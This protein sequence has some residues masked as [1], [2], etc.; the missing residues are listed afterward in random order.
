M[1]RDTTNAMTNRKNNTFAMPAAPEAMPP[2]PKTAAMIATMKKPIAQLSMVDS[3]VDVMPQPVQTVCPCCAANRPRIG[4]VES[5]RYGLPLSTASGEAAKA[6]REGIDLHLS[7][8]PGAEQRLLQAL[9]ADEGF[10]LAHAALARHRQLYGRMAE[11]RASIARA[12]ALGGSAREQGHV[13]I[14]G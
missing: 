12:R 3:E 6:Y 14:L 9:A 1:I 5:D 11:A 4:A 8:Y 10:A 7:G 2:N 13:G